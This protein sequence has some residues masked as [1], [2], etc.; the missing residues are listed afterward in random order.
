MPQIFVMP[1]QLALDDDA[2]PMAGALLYFFRTGTTELQA[3]YS[4][5]AL[6]TQHQNPVPADSAGEFPKIYLNSGA[7]S[8]YRVRL[9]TAS[10]VQL[11]QEDEIE[12]FTVSQ[13]EM[14]T[15]LNPRTSTEI[16]A[17]ATP[18]NFAIPSHET[19]GYV[20]IE[21][22]G[23][24]SSPGT[25]DMRDAIHAALAVARSARIRRVTSISSV[26][27][28]TDTVDLQSYTHL[29]LAFGESASGGGPIESGTEIR[30]IGANNG[31]VI[32]AFNCRLFECSG[33]YVNSNGRT[34]LT[35]FLLDSNNNPSGSQNTIHHFSIRECLIGVQWGTSGIANGAY[36][37]DGT[38]FHTFTI[39]SNEALSDGFVIN[40]GN[41]GQMSIIRNGGIQTQ[42]RGI[43]IQVANILKIQQVFGGAV[44]DDAFIRMATGIDITID[45]CSSECWGLGRTWRTNRPKFLRVVKPVGSGDEDIYP[46][47]ECAIKMSGN[48]INNPI[49]LGYPVRLVSS[50]D[51]WGFCQDYDTGVFEGAM[52]HAVAGPEWSALT[53]Y[54]ERDVVT[55]NGLPYF[56]ILGNTNQAPPNATY[57]SD[58]RGKS[59]V[60]SLN[61][62]VSPQSTDLTTNQPIHGWV[63]SNYIHLSL[64][65]PG[66]AWVRP[67]FD[68]AT[69]DAAGSTTWTVA[70]GDV[71][72]FEYKLI[73]RTMTVSFRIVTSSVSDSSSTELRITI[74]A[75]KKVS[76]PMANAVW[77][78]DN[79][80]AEIGVAVVEIGETFIRI[81][82]MAGG[83]FTTATNTT[84]VKGQLTFLVD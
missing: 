1:R 51:S 32:R 12:R 18:V 62:G 66:R 79:G 53:S 2:N 70:A 65:D 82:R 73:E 26:L 16:A 7:T 42:R 21:R 8:N 69:Y 27:A 9:T 63:D 25:T 15:V 57:W 55:H 84:A 31:T 47:I 39:W 6:T 30:W 37:N 71:E 50:A 56:C 10:G 43:D 45:C 58:A 52:G 76:R 67:A 40:S 48:Q 28:V 81:N 4:D 22:Y 80:T 46:I 49:E 36:A 77:I 72:S 68:A 74:P 29:D 17:A 35:G 5:A 20:I 54:E 83:A 13:S 23:D 3:V 14:T 44:V 75:G 11:Y 64:I 61:N 60:V 38:E 78:S 41:A 59:R 19:C 24:N 33:F 34:G